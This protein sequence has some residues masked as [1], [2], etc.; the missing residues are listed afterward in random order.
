[1]LER[2][3]YIFFLKIHFFIF[4]LGS[5]IG[6]KTTDSGGEREGGEG[7]G[8]KILSK[9]PIQKYKGRCNVDL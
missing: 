4:L 8:M 1:M 6:K 3:E 9:C 2:K 7:R 5:D